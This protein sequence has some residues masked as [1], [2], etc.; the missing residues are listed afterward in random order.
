ML[1]SFPDMEIIDCSH[2]IDEH[3][4]TFPRPWHKRV[5]VETLG[6]LEE[7]GRRSSHVAMGTHSGTHIDAPSHFIEAGN[8]ID[9][10]SLTRLFGIGVVVNIDFGKPC[11]ALN[12]NLLSSK[13]K[14]NFENK[15]IFLNF[16]WGH[17]F[18]RGM[19]YYDQQPWFDIETAELINSLNPKLVGYDLAMLDNPKEGFG[20]TVDSPI[21]KLFLSRGIPLLENAIFPKN[22]EG[23]VSFAA[24][25]LR[26]RGL[27]GSPVRFILWR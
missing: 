22:F 26:L 20:C 19:Q 14:Q 10:V 9:E 7:V 3:L 17:T 18:H 27:D 23:E 15:A 12:P 13:L 8:S 24:F 5:T 6:K 16:N 4:T 11:A 21:H 1:N 25:P 2:A